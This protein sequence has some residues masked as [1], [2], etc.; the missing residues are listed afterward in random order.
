MRRRAIP[1]LLAALLA[2]LTAVYTGWWLSASGRLRDAA[3]AWIDQRKAEGFRLDHGTPARAGFPLSLG[4]RFPD[5]EA[6]PPG[7]GW[8]WRSADVRLLAPLIGRRAPTV[9]LEGEQALAIPDG[10]AG[11]RGRRFAGGA[12]RLALTLDPQADGALARLTVRQLAMAEGGDGF[13]VGDLDLLVS[14]PTAGEGDSAGALSLE[15]DGVRLP[16]AAAT[17]LGR[18][19]SRVELRAR[20]IG[21]IEPPFGP[22]AV[23]AWRDGGGTVEIDR[24]RCDYGSVNLEADGTLALDVRGQPI[25]AFATHVQGWQAA[26]DSLAAAQAIPAHTAAAAK[27]LMRGLARGN[28]ERGGTLSA[29]LSLQDRTLS[30]G[31]VPLLRLPEVP[32]LEPHPR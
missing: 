22:A 19:V 27:I 10:L 31:P 30:L 6:A 17:A 5:V 7:A 11:G 21:A 16:A 13:V 24:L 9:F 14:K 32:W 26:L 15:A 3:L 1:I 23:K 20:L 18:E 25:G 2:L 12:D 4:V 8:S 29:P 28:G